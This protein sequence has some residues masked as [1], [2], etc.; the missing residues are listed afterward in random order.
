LEAA[1][2]RPDADLRAAIGDALVTTDRL[3]TTITEL[4]ALARHTARP[5]DNLDVPALRDGIR[6]RWH[7]DLAARGRPLR[8]SVDGQPQVRVSVSALDQILDVLIDNADRHGAGAITVRIRAT[9]GAVAFEVADDGPALPADAAAALVDRKTQLDDG[10]GIGLS[11]AR[12]LAESQGGRLN[13]SRLDPPTFTV[14]IPVQPADVPD[15]VE[16]S[17]NRM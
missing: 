5:A 3:T 11:L 16:S 7:A 10:H 12:R 2:D 15:Q 17:G 13:L 14:L 1:L 9:A 8:V 6:R 4:L